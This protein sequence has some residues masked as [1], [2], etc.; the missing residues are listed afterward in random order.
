VKKQAIIRFTIYIKLVS[1]RYPLTSAFKQCKEAQYFGIIV[2]YLSFLN[3]RNLHFEF[4]SKVL[5]VNWWRNNRMLNAR[6]E[7]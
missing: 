1:L 4:N 5:L 6:P 2:N 3:Q 7:L